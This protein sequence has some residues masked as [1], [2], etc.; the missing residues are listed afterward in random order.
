MRI[1]ETHNQ[2]KSKSE[3]QVQNAVVGR[4]KNTPRACIQTYT[5]HPLP[6]IKH[7]NDLQTRIQ[8]YPAR[9]MNLTVEWYQTKFNLEKFILAPFITA[10]HWKFGY[11][12]ADKQPKEKKT[13]KTSPSQK[14]KKGK[15]MGLVRC[16]NTFCFMKA[17][18]GLEEGLLPPRSLFEVQWKCQQKTCTSAAR[19]LP[20][21]A[22]AGDY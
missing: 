8:F 15:S 6:Q 12:I 16:E 14:K 9:N 11:E 21:I 7:E 19:K 4:I 5:M 20:P 18:A 2:V 13:E 22:T 3:R 10:G 17:D 1:L